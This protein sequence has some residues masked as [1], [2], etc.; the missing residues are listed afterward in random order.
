MGPKWV[1][2]FHQGSPYPKPDTK[3]TEHQD[4]EGL[5]CGASGHL[6][7]DQSQQITRGHHLLQSLFIAPQDLCITPGREPSP[8]MRKIGA[9]RDWG[10]QKWN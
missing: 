7:N 5:C 1:K 2:R 10:T 8:I 3:A 4:P 9:Q 6:N